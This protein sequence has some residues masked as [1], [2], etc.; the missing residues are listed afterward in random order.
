MKSPS[1]DNAPIKVTHI[2]TGLDVG[3]AEM[4]LY[5]LLAGLDRERVDCRVVSL[6]GGGEMADRIR[7]LGIPVSSLQ[8]SGGVSALGGLFK[9]YGLLRTSKPDVVQTW[10]YHADLLG[11]V[12]AKLARIPAIAWNLRCSDMGESY[13]RGSTGVIIRALALLSAQ[14]EAV[15][16][17]SEAGKNLHAKLGYRPRAWHIIPNGF[18]LDKF[19]PEPE[20]RALTRESL[21]YNDENVVIGLVGRF[22]PVKGHGVFLEAAKLLAASNPSARFVLVGAGYT[23]DNRELTEASGAGLD[24][25]VKFLGRRDDIPAVM[26]SLDILTCASLG[27]GFPNVLGEA[28]ACGT[29]CVATDGGDCARIID[30]TGRVAPPSNPEKLA[31]AWSEIIELGPQGRAEL[32]E[33]ARHRIAENYD[34]N[35]IVKKYETL[36]RDLASSSR[37]R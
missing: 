23:P 28:M 22:D 4:M 12:G 33:Q 19:R 10:L 20:L 25:V 34:L 36:Y 9:L 15:V 6:I 8:M 7:S 32:G 1:G 30:D 31:L 29:P 26:A 13:Y 35:I 14:P 5:K 21:G 3:G 16:T 11:Y 2:I 37:L 24:K 18:E 27:E 17:N